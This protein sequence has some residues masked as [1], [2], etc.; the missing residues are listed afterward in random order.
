MSHYSRLR[1]SHTQPN[2][3]K[4]GLQPHA[5]Q[6]FKLPTRSCEHHKKQSI[7]ECPR[8]LSHPEKGVSWS[9]PLHHLLRTAVYHSIHSPSL[10][11]LYGLNQQ[12]DRGGAKSNKNHVFL[13]HNYQQSSRIQQT[14]A[15]TNSLSS[16]YPVLPKTEGINHHAEVLLDSCGA[17]GDWASRGNMRRA[18]HVLVSAM[19]RDSGGKERSS[20]TVPLWIISFPAIDPDS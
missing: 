16:K 13:K 12:T 8:T 4:F 3:L 5:S 19:V 7:Q 14:S 20:T 6:S 15:P 17:P 10:I 2:P 18:K 1:K 11:E 9:I